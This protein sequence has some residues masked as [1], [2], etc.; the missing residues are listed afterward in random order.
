[1]ENKFFFLTRNFVAFVTIYVINNM[2][3]P[4]KNNLKFKPSAIKLFVL[5]L[6]LMVIN[7]D[8]ARSDSKRL[9]NA[10]IAA[11]LDRLAMD[12]SDLKTQI[13]NLT[14]TVNSLTAKDKESI[15]KATLTTDIN[16]LIEP[17][18]LTMA[19]LEN[20]LNILSA[21]QANMQKRLN[22]VEQRTRYADSIN[23]EILSQLVILENRLASLSNSIS[24][25]N[26]ASQTDARQATNRAI[27]SPGITYKDRYLNALSLH[28]KGKFEEAIALFR[29][30]IADDPTNELADNAQYWI[31]ESYYSMKQ[32]QQ[33]IIEFEKV[34][35]FTNTDKD[36]DAQ[37]KI[38][39]CFK[40]MGD[41]K[42][43]KDELEKL[44]NLYPT[45]EY[46]ESAKQ[47]IK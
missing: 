44:I 11:S 27:T 34:R 22:T 21:E 36:D 45:S 47:L 40:Q 2:Q 20:R 17:L 15:T 1:M 32:Y 3:Q 28:Q 33:A 13:A 38:G 29:K 23:F 16:K 6:S 9:S 25:Y 39:L 19:N 8:L 31:G 37:Y 18:Q 24:D 30:L 10:E 7:L 42:R 4:I 12:I 35:N 41:Q 5:A 43:A 26:S 14:K 46:S